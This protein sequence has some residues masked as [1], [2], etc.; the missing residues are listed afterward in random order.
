MRYSFILCLTAFYSLPLYVADPGVAAL[1]EAGR[2]RKAQPLLEAAVKSNLND[3]DALYQ[4]SR[5]K[6]VSEETDAALTLA[7]KAAALQPKNATYRFQVASVVARQAQQASVFR[8]IGLARKF[9]REGDAALALDA[10]HLDALEF[11]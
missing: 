7:E 9:R 5:V 10:N 1:V 2:W 8:Q 6:M 4:L 11:M 3:A